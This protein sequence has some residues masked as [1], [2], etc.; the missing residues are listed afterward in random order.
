MIAGVLIPSVS[1]QVS[2]SQINPSAAA[3]RDLYERAQYEDA[4]RMLDT[5]IQQGNI[6]AEILYYRGLVEPEALVAVELY[7]DRVYRRYPGTEW[8][9][10]ALFKIAQY[11]YDSAMYIKARGLFGD[12]AWSQG[13]SSLGQAARYWRGMTWLHTS[14]EPDSLRI[15]LRIIKS[16]AIRSTD[17]ETKGSALL[18]TAELSLRLGEPDSA[19][20]YAAAV[21]E[22]PYLEDQHPR[23]M[24]IQARAYDVLGD[25]DQARIMNQTLVNRFP[26]TLDGREARRW[27]A[28][29]REAIVQARLDSMRAMGTPGM[30][31]GA[32]DE[33]RWSV[34]VGAYSNLGNA[35]NQVMKLTREGYDAWHTT[36][37]VEGRFFVVVLVGRFETRA[38]A[39]A[40]GRSLVETSPSV[41]SY[42]LYEINPQ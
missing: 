21:I 26:D 38:E 32:V 12:V 16:A 29:Q 4:R 27:L 18:S 36:K 24:G 10:R 1:A 5:L 7:F 14:G 35:T 42:Q 13:N 6:T 23:A 22:A 20:T 8:G 41:P 9:S 31:Q 28:Q 30:T 17:P 15:G 34:Q 37:Q 25:L 3:A 33:G 39:N 19:F 11:W 40:F 2:G